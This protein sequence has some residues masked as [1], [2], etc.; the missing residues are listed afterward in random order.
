MKKSSFFLAQI[1]VFLFFLL[2]FASC[3]TTETVKEE[4]TAEPMSPVWGL[5]RRGDD[6]ARGYFHGQMGVNETD[7]NGRTPLHYAAERNDAHLAAFFIAL[8]ANVNAL[9][10]E[11]QSSL[12]ISVYNKDPFVANVIATS[13]SANIHIELPCGNT[14]AAFALE[15]DPEVFRAL[16]NPATIASSDESGRT[17]LHLAS[18]NG[19]LSAVEN[20]LG[21]LP[22]SNASINQRDAQNK[23]ALDYALSNPNSKSHIES[24]EKLILSGANSDDPIFTY[25]GPAVR[26]ANYNTRRNEGLAPIHYAV[27]ENHSGMI[28]FLLDKNIEIDIKSTSGAT[29]LHEAVRIG[30]MEVIMLLIEKGADVNAVDAK[31]NTPL[32][33]GIPPEFHRDVITVL[34]ANGANPNLRDMHGDTP[35]HIAVILN[36]SSDIIQA[37]LNGRSDVHVRN[38]EGKTPLYI[39]VQEKRT[40]LIPVLLTYGSEIFAADN[41]GTSPFD[42]AAR[43]NDSTFE[44][45]ITEETVN[46]RDSAGNTMLHAVVRNM[47]N[48]VQIGKILEKRAPVDARNRDGD[49]A[50]HFAVRLNQ[51]ETGEF[52][53]LREASIYS[54]NSAGQSPLFLALSPVN[55]GGMREWIINPTTINAKDGLGNNMLHFAAEWNLINAIPIIVRNGV[56]PDEANST[57]QTPLFLAVRTNSPASIRILADNNAS[58]NVRDTQG[59]SLLHSAVRWNAKDSASLLLSLGADINGFSLNGNTPLHD[60]VSLKYSEIETLLIQNNAN[61]EVRNIDGNTPFMEAVRAGFIPSI[62]KLAQNGADFST[63]NIRGDT[64]LHIAVDMERLEVASML[65]SMGASIH[66]R[67]TRNVTPFMIAINKSQR[68]VSMLLSG[69][70]INISDDHGNSALHVALNE[71]APAEIIRTIV[72]TGAR[73]N[74]VDS[75][76]KTP[77]RLS[78]DL[79][80]W[81]SVKIIADAGAD[82]FMSASDNKTP[83]EIAFS[84]GGECIRALFSGR[85]INSRDSSGNTILH[86]AARHGSPESI[87][88]LLELGANRSIRNIA[89]E[90]AFD[91]AIRW[92]RADNAELLRS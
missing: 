44:L 88:I 91:I 33:T 60:A 86:I 15:N 26:T 43:A 75:N 62:E 12:G 31:G 67:N 45:L 55:G 2:L 29:A 7:P 49:T 83:A 56:S 19:N 87:S 52:L 3:E 68:L 27:I 66:A 51:R 70:R 77:L 71:K 25:F 34:L 92:N 41:S 58:L 6:R 65:L 61:L 11:G 72:N 22:L 20:I 48:S 10:N 53:I 64:P 74:A 9:D 57:G 32:H 89:S 4:P 46:S 14:A 16:L 8:G 18:Q 50:L 90:S 79:N 85:A 37:L 80:Q 47:G 40:E 54:L 63:R 78:I 35:L 17:A 28:S 73:I 76:G 84:K 13:P 36:R 21:I 30:N 39:A 5:L 81:E 24:A 59:N 23:T 38:I 1:C 82:P 42:I 69:N